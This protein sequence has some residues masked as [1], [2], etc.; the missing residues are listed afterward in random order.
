MQYQLFLYITIPGM[1]CY[2]FNKI[3]YAWKIIYSHPISVIPSYSFSNNLGKN[4]IDREESRKLDLNVQKMK[5]RRKKWVA[6]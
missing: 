3:L 5:A 6:E 2:I 4:E 1:G